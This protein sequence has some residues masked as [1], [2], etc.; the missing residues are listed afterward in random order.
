MYGEKG[1]GQIINK[2]GRAVGEWEA[3]NFTK[4]AAAGY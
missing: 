2:F 3:K 4:N 1:A